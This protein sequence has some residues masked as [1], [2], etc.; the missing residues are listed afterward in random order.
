MLHRSASET[1]PRPQN[2]VPSPAPPMPPRYIPQNAKATVYSAPG[3][4]EMLSTP[5]V[6]PELP[7]PNLYPDP[8]PSY[9]QRQRHYHQS[10]MT[11][12]PPI[13]LFSEGSS[14]ASTRSSLAYTNPP[15]GLRNSDHY[16]T[17]EDHSRR[18]PMSALYPSDTSY[19]V[20][21]A[22]VSGELD[23]AD[24]VG[25]ALTSDEVAHLSHSA[26]ASSFTSVSGQQP[27]DPKRWS[28]SSLGRPVG[29][30]SGLNN[31]TSYDWSAVDEREE[32]DVPT[33]S[34][35]DVYDDEDVDEDD[36]EAERTAAIVM[37][38]E[39]KGLIVRGEG[40]SVDSLIIHSG[41]THL[42]LAGSSTPNQMP[43]FL[44]S[45]LLSIPNT[46]LAL[47]ISCNM[48]P[49]L[50]PVLASCNVLEELNVAANPLRVLPAWLSELKSLRVL[51]A[52]S[53]G[54]TALPQSMVILS[55]LHTF[56]IRRNRLYSLPSWLCTLSSL[57][58]LLLEG[59][60]F[61]E[62][63]ASLIAPLIT[64]DSSP[65]TPAYPTNSPQNAT[66][67]IFTP[68]AYT[69]PAPDVQQ[70][71]QAPSSPPKTPLPSLGG[72]SVPE[73]TLRRSMSMTSPYRR[74]AQPSLYSVTGSRPPSSAYAASTPV[75]N[76]VEMIS[77]RPRAPARPST[78]GAGAVSSVSL[79]GAY[80]SALNP[81]DES[82]DMDAIDSK[83]RTPTSTASRG[84]IRR[85]KS[86]DELSRMTAPKTSKSPQPEDGLDSRLRKF[87]S[88]P[89]VAVRPDRSRV[90]VSMWSEVGAPSNSTASARLTSQS[91]YVREP[92]S[93]DGEK[94][95][96]TKKW[97]FLKK[98]SMSRM[99]S[100][101]T[102]KDSSRAAF[103]RAQS[104][105]DLASIPKSARSALP[106]HTVAS[107]E[108]PVANLL[109]DPG[110][111]EPFAPLEV[112]TV[113]A[114]PMLPQ[115][116]P[117][118]PLP[119]PSL[120]MSEVLI[121]EE[122]ELPVP[123]PLPPPKPNLQ[124]KQSM[125]LLAQ[126][127]TTL[128]PPSP[129]T[130]V[131]RAQRRRSFLPLNLI[132]SN[133]QPLNI[134]IPSPGPFVPDAVAV[135]GSASPAE[136]V[137]SVPPV[138]PLPEMTPLDEEVEAMRR[139]EAHAR[140]L[141]SIMAYLKDLSD[142]NGPIVP[143]IPSSP[144]P[145]SSPNSPTNSAQKRRPTLNSDSRVFSESSFV[146]ISSQPS[147]ISGQLSK[148]QSM[149]SLR[150]GAMSITTTES[151]GSAG[152]T[153][154]RKCK[155]DKAK[156]TEIVKE[157]V[158][159][160]R[161][162]VSQLQEL[163]DIYVKPSTEYITSAF[164][165]QSNKETV[166]P[167]TERRIVF[168]GLESLY[169][170]HKDAFLPAPRW[171]D[172]L[173]RRGQIAMVF[174][175]QAAFMR[176]YQTYINNFDNAVARLRKWNE[177]PTGNITP[178]AGATNIV[179]LGLT[180]SAVAGI[181][182]DT[183]AANNTPLTTSQR[184]RIKAFMKR[185]RVNPR[186]SQMDLQAYL[187]LPVQRIPRYKLFLENLSHCTPPKNSAFEDPLEIALR[188]I[189]SVADNM[190]EGKRE[191]EARQKL[192]NWQAKIRGKFPS[193]LVQ[194]HRRLIM[195]GHLSLS[196]VVRK[197]ATYAE[198]FKPDG[199]R[200]SQ[201]KDPICPYDLWAVLRMQTSLQPASVV[202][203]STLRLV[204]N[205]AILYFEAATTSDAL[206]WSRAINQHIPSSR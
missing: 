202:H 55:A 103:A 117:T 102:P 199:E 159:T 26:S 100:G 64:S 99:R 15:Y 36:V 22:D 191:A 40:K 129:A 121:E 2:R 118:A 44:S 6:V 133:G 161:T 156:R 93:P 151:G 84:P 124:K 112:P 136:D 25:L 167:T 116:R 198:V 12:T 119:L 164:G 11:M 30:A 187:L 3:L 10:G 109:R 41:V 45:A 56:S 17:S 87:D 172:I 7:D 9:H 53:T 132:A 43:V 105:T 24:A 73:S 58:T 165:T 157:I 193:P 80:L 4:V 18:G 37:A 33:D 201:G 110:S 79:V 95:D 57:E 67:A 14:S 158:K 152:N 205:K 180:M 48:L 52:D 140:A 173:W 32:Y 186:H 35:T 78:A 150:N 76:G 39:G 31:Q 69:P 147:S 206:T 142:L 128:A 189:S 146:S 60:P 185:S 125:E 143:E 13:S 192:I 139:R 83:P 21:E 23:P 70:E 162:Y 34:E 170:F 126:L 174:V 16:D 149:A 81:T 68:E 74:G 134:P 111:V 120:T 138:P 72:P 54:I 101:S 107:P 171:R 160:E 204:D 179:G 98:M 137:S 27:S 127:V 114:T 115:F 61:I 46:L 63:W 5:L 135:N 178:A 203:G 77:A 145:S 130:P 148:K 153:E 195:D 122:E 197:S 82:D 49:A 20:G 141:R 188:D 65:M 47:D 154:E 75:Q 94:A 71:A 190:N 91:V 62:P 184:K 144:T 183:P 163:I 155:E 181:A 86:A 88:L 29:D 85:M 123:P 176:L 182:P 168:N 131:H 28:G 194:P 196:R 50:P 38:E 97:G 96:K 8:Y 166:I 108:F 89:R 19:E 175:S 113:T 90:P 104:A 106:I 51:I 59:N 42:L 200:P 92:T 177:K 1:S 66:N 169:Q